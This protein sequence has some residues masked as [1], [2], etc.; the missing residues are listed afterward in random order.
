MSPEQFEELFDPPDILMINVHAD[1]Y[2]Q[3]IGDFFDIADY[4]VK[5]STSRRQRTHSI[6]YVGRTVDTYLS[7]RYSNFSERDRFCSV[8]KVPIGCHIREVDSPRVLRDLLK[9][10]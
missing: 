1:S 10:R 2:V 6:M 9:V 8:E 3:D 4:P 7:E 5:G